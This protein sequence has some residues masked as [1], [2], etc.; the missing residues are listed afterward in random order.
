MENVERQEAHYRQ[1]LLYYRNLLQIL[2]QHPHQRTTS[3]HR[4]TDDPGRDQVLWRAEEYQIPQKEY[5]LDY[6][7]PKEVTNAQEIRNL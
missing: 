6:C 3:I 7:G 5:L 2:L 4:P 1:G